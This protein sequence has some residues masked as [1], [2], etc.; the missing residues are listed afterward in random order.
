MI[1]AYC[2]ELKQAS[3]YEEIM[4]HMFSHHLR[5]LTEMLVFFYCFGACV[6]YLVVMGDQIEDSKIILDC[7]LLVDACICTLP[8]F[9]LEWMRVSLEKQLVGG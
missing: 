2:A 5:S 6:T 4:E 7:I 3:T 8:Y 9:L 1:L